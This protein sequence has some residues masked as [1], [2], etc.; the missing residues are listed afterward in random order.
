[1]FRV[2]SRVSRRV[3]RRVGKVEVRPPGTP[4]IMLCVTYVMFTSFT[5]VVYVFR[6]CQ[7]PSRDDSGPILWVFACVSMA[8]RMRECANALV[9]HLRRH[10]AARRRHG[11]APAWFLVAA[12]SPC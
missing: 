11:G 10:F 3:P 4:V 2:Y 12:A 1:M 7:A 9:I 8:S 6:P 5:H